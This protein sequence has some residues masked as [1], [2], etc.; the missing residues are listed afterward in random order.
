MITFMVVNG[1]SLLELRKLYID[2]F[3]DFYEHLFFTLEQTGKI[4]EGSHAKIASKTRGSEAGAK[5]TVSLLRK[6]MFRSI[7]DKNKKTK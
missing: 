6:Q 4:K 5:E 2:E 1:F 7:A 3:Y